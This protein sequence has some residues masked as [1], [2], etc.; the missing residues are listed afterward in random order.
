MEDLRQKFVCSSPVK[1]LRNSVLR[2]LRRAI[3]T[4]LQGAEINDS[5]QE[6]LREVIRYYENRDKH[7]ECF[8]IIAGAPGLTISGYVISGSFM[9]AVVILQADS[10]Q[11]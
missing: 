6:I 2:H 5:C 3:R 7:H 10:L 11:F 8:R 9:M 4:E 1:P